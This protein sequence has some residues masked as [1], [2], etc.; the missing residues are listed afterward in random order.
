[1]FLA[2]SPLSRC[3]RA[4]SRSARVLRVMRSLVDVPACAAYVL[5]A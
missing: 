1:L 3:P 4:I 5:P 2:Q